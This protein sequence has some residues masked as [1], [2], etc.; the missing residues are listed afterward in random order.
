MSVLA[1]L[2]V[3]D[4]EIYLQGPPETGRGYVRRLADRC[5][6]AGVR[7]GSV[8][9][10]VFGFENL[11]YTTYRRQQLWALRQFE[12]YVQICAELG[13]AHYVAHGPPRHHV[14][15]DGRM[16]DRY[17][18]VTAEL[19]ETARSHGV[20]YCMENVSYGLLR[21]PADVAAHRAA[22]DVPVPIV[23]D[24]KSAWKA[25]LRPQDFAAALGEDIAFVHISF[26]DHVGAR[27]GLCPGTDLPDPDLTAMVGTLT[28]M[29][30]APPRTV[31]EVCGA[32]DIHA[33]EA[34]VAA[35]E[36][37]LAPHT[38]PGGP[39]GGRA[40]TGGAGPSYTSSEGERCRS[41]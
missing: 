10:Y 40:V 33:V 4:V 14:V 23:L 15:D 3:R 26:P 36:S 31:V 19:V 2:G 24:V 11:L 21:D 29:H 17:L 32:S 1:G 34:A 20:V 16:S 6:E 7:V 12:R 30:G 22:L 41:T 25:G 13:A 9:P 37:L 39:G 8:H 35:T 38:G 18:A 27:Y 28:A 5:R